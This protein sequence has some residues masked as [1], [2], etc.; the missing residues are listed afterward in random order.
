MREKEVSEREMEMLATGCFNYY[1]NKEQLIPGTLSFIN[2][3]KEKSYLLDDYTMNYI[4]DTLTVELIDCDASVHDLWHD[5]L[6]HLVGE[7]T[8]ESDFDVSSCLDS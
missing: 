2:F 6:K 7:S 4:I 3:I 1:L 8:F 5:L